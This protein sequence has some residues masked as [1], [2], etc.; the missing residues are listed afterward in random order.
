MGDSEPP[1]DRVRT[2]Y[3]AVAE[4]YERRFVD[5]LEHKPL[6]CAL[7]GVFADDV[8]PGGVVGDVG[9]GPGHIAGQL[10]HLGLR[11]VGIDLSSRMIEL[12]RHRFPGIDFVVGSMLALPADDDSWAGMVAFYSIIHL[13]PEELAQAFAEFA[14]V[15]RPG[16]P[17]L[18][19]FHIGGEVRH[20]DELFD[21]PVSLDFHLLRPAEVT[22]LLQ[23]EGFTIEWS[24]ERAP[25]VTVEAPTQ[26]SYLLA[27]LSQSGGMISR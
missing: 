22:R 14:R 13:S 11:P 4:A 3:D 5:E 2:S 21:Q 27:R 10:Y 9:C 20:F 1:A 12:A 17:L 16:A 8:G 7:L 23:A 6:D 15:L 26:R 18:L 25:Y 19:A 24:L